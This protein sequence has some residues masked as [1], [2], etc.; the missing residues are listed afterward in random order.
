M[1]ENVTKDVQYLGKDFA[2]LR[3]NLINFAQIYFP[4][5]YN[6]FNESSPGMMFIE[7]A[8]YVGD[9]L[10][11]YI[12]NA[13]NEN[14]LSNAKQR[15]N[16]YEIAESLGYKPKTTSPAKTN[17]QIYQTL[18]VKG[19]GITSEPDYDYALVVKAG[20]EFSSTT[21]ST[22]TFITDIDLDFSVSS[23][24][25][26][27]EVTIYS[28]EENTSQP[29]YYLLKKSVPATAATLKTQTFSFN[30]PEKFGIV[31]LPES[32]VI[33]IISCTDSDNN[34]WYEVPYLGQETVFE[35][36]ENTAKYD[37]EL[38]QYNDTAPYLL[39][40]KKSSRRF[41]TRVLPE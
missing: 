21:D 1:A 31:N 32:N 34:K 4:N 17:L 30:T 8:A 36:V 24:F 15:K 33:R 22:V 9:V 19:T 38:A 10:N 28:V 23:S 7:M 20:S 13:V 2:S 41:Q 25:D 18:P 26:N 35:E 5:S 27:T 11:Y 14:L 6:D 29:L 37:T 16:V 12:D 40:L 3:G 39:R